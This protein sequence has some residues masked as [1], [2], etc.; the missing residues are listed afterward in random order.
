MA[1]L[2][3]ISKVITVLTLRYLIISTIAI[4]LYLVNFISGYIVNIY[5]RAFALSLSLVAEQLWHIVIVYAT[6]TLF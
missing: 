5:L 1:V 3:P 4:W 6:Y 2:T